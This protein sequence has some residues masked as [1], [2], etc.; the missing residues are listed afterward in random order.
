MRKYKLITCIIM[1]AAALLSSCSKNL[2]DKYPLSDVSPQKFFNTE[3]DLI[4]YTNSFYT[5]TNGSSVF[6]GDIS[7]DNVEQNSVNQLLAG[8]M[9]V[10]ET[11]SAAG[12]TWSDLRKFNYFLV[13]YHRAAVNESIKNNYAG[14][15]RFFRA[16]FYFEKMKRFGAVPWY[17]TPLETNSPE[18][19]KGR[20]SR[21]LITDSILA[22][23]DFAIANLNTTKNVSRV[24]KWTAMALKSRVCLFE[25]TFRKYHTYLNLGSSANALLQQAVAAAEQVM[26]GNVYK[27]YST[28]QP[29]KDYMDLFSSDH[30]KADEIILA[31][32]YD[33]ELK[34]FHAANSIF[35]VATTGGGVGLTKD[36]MDNYLM[37]NGKPFS[38]VAGYDTMQFYP[39][40]RNRDPRLAQTIRT[41]GYKR[42][43]GTQELLPDFT[44]APTGYQVIKFVSGVDQ[45]NYSTNS[46]DV[47]LFRYAEVLLNFA[48]AKA[49]LG[50]LTQTDVD[51]SIN[52]LRKRAGVANLV[53]SALQT[54]PLLT[55]QYP[56]ITDNYILEVRR[57]RRIELVMEGFRYYDI[58]RWKLGKNLEKVFRGMYF[59]SKGEHDLN[60]DGKKDFAVV[61]AVPNPKTPG[62]QYFVLGTRKLSQRDMGNL[63]VSPNIIKK[64]EEPK[65]YF[66]PLPR[67]EM[68]LNPALKPQNEGWE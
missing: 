8:N 61:D 6:M 37:T 56:G 42:I 5:F 27:L 67:A 12:W 34:K 16:W 50:S 60:G 68:V 47:P 23:L 62:V 4:L 18:L 2:L 36:L 44:A 32:V 58:I 52:L 40:T 41:P 55:A 20:D 53:L 57:E 29:Q 22:D 21:V 49:E 59:S 31:E 10:P 46:N 25:G 17:S 7:S 26:A 15:A 3:Q 54:D 24:N 38:S 51:R 39:E 63:L 65:N 9:Q 28:N 43:G 1:V 48:E 64:F 11:A 35:N 45:D 13:N 66:Y 33:T 19:Y 14:L 30:A